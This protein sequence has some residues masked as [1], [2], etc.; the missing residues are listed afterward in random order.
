MTSFKYYFIY[1][2]RNQINNKIYI[3]F[4]ATDI[5]ED[6]YMGSGIAINEAYKKYGK[7]NFK[8]E[9][10]EYCNESNWS[11]REK[12]W[13][14]KLNTYKKGYNMTIGGEGTL[15]LKLSDEIKKKISDSKMGRPSWNKGKK[16]IYSDETRNNWSNKR[17]KIFP[18][19]AHKLKISKANKGRIKS[20]AEIE[21]LSLAKIGN[22]NPAIRIDVREKVSKSLKGKFCG[23][24]NPM[25]NRSRSNEELKKYKEQGI[26]LKGDRWEYMRKKIK[27]IDLKTGEELILDGIK[28]LQSKIGVSK[29]KYYRALKNPSILPRYRFGNII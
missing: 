21:K 14:E 10:L 6:G 1:S 27:C 24:N 29:N 17:K 4:H 2:I 22:K 5:L 3:G 20:D 19:D 18:S 8:R 7:K 15:G 11:K 9:I 12:Y 23:E 25:Y 28:D 16:G 26:E 13:I